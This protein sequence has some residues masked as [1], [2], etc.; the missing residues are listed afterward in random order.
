MSSDDNR[1]FE[2]HV[3]KIGNQATDF[4]ASERPRVADLGAER[5]AGID[6]S[7][8]NWI[9]SAIIGREIPQ[10]GHD[11]NANECPSIAP[12]PNLTYRIHRSFQIDTRQAAEPGRSRRNH[13]RRLFV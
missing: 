7:R 3:F 10:P 5:Y 2:H 1:E 6:A 4:G 12:A 8:I 13:L 9:V 11:T